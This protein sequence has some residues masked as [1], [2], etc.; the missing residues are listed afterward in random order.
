MLSW[1]RGEVKWE[2]AEIPCELK[3][4]EF[5]AGI[6]CTTRQIHQ[7]YEILNFLSVPAGATLMTLIF[8]VTGQGNKIAKPAMILT[9]M[10][11]RFTYLTATPMHLN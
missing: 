4:R 10:E 5:C 11:Q 7:E 8:S 6:N 3:G 2:T 1:G 9:E